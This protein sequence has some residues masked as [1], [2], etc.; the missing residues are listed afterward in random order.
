[1][2]RIQS[3][4]KTE[5]IESQ[6]LRPD[7]F[8]Q[9][10]ESL[11]N[12][13]VIARGSGLNY[14]MA[15]AIDGGSSVLSAQFNRFLAFDHDQRV[16]RVEPSIT[17]GE[18]LEF[19]VAHGLMP[20]VL[21]GYPR[22]TVGGALAMNVHGKNQYRS[23][24][25]GDH[26]KRLSIYHPRYG[27]L[28]CST[29]EN[30][31]LFYLTIGG[32]GLT[33]F[34]VSAD[35]SLEPIRGKSVLVERHKVRNLSDAVERMYLLAD[36]SDFLYSWHDF[37]LKGKEFGRGFVYQERFSHEEFTITAGKPISSNFRPMPCAFLN[38][39]TVP[40]I[41]NGYYLKQQMTPKFK[42]SSLYQATFPIVGKEIYFRLFGHRGFR[43][44][45]VL[46]S[47]ES[48]KGALERIELA[49]Q[50]SGVPI[51]LASLKLFRGKRRLLNFVGD[52]I[53]LA[54]DAPN[55]PKSFALFSILDE[56][57]IHFGGIS[58]VSKDG[59]LSS[60]I[61]QQMYEGYIEFSLALRSYDDKAHF[62]SE[63]RRRIGV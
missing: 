44:Y 36:R 57:A 55:T 17:M 8:R 24:N 7:R 61:L 60:E 19:A 9:L 43:E 15:S 34:I 32:F 38:R 52:G 58:N 4:D 39:L 25:F 33:G 35:I 30:S 45:Q 3:F 27:V 2:T 14:C 53:C 59:R 50:S 23:G 29:E 46:F 11:S 49:I 6:L 63:L 12:A 51:T 10:F 26:V 21:P 41:C 31:E 22:I 62:Q 40:L 37:N 42:I 1:M 28:N 54:L 5:E 48:W 18:L 47:N 20:P 13:K 16:I 56:I